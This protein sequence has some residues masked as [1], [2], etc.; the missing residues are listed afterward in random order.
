SQNRLDYASQN[1]ATSMENTEA[2]RSSLI[3]LDVAGAMSDLAGQ[4]TLMQAGLAMHAQANS[5]RS[6]I[7]KLLA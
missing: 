4:Q 6:S 1:I 5:N 7:L 2:A 3:D